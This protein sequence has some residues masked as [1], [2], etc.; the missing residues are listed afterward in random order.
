VGEVNFSDR[1]IQMTRSFR[2]LKLWMSLKVFGHA[3]FEK[4]LNR[5]FESAEVAEETVRQLPGWEVVTPAQM[6]IV[7]FRCVP[8]GLAPGEV[9]RLNRQLVEEM[10]GDGFAMVSSTVLRGLTVLRMCTINP[11]TTDAGIQETIRRLNHMA[12]RLTA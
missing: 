11:H 7:T 5:T 3:A 4:E 8:R 2:A 6:A 9:N 10:I 1:G 12:K